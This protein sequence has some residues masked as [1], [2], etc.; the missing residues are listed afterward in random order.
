ML[1]IFTDRIRRMREGN[2]FSLFTPRG[3]PEPG[4]AGGGGVVPEPGP[5][6]GRGG[7]RSGPA[8]GG[9]L[10]QV[11]PGGTPMGGVTPTGGYP[12]SGT[13]HQTWTGGTPVGGGY[14]TSV[15]RWSTW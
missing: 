14:P 12:T 3:V 13:P 1:L 5:A 7:T 6:G 10:S 9:Y 15:N 4:P 11:Q 8:W 2:V